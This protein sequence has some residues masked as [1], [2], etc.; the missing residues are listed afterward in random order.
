MPGEQY[1]DASP[2][3]S[4]RPRTVRLDH[5][6]VQADLVTDRG[7]FSPTRIDLGTRV[8]FDLA[9]EPPTAGRFLDLGCGYGPIAVVLATLCPDAEVWAV[10]VNE[11]SLDLTRRNCA[12]LPNVHV[13]A[14]DEVDPALRFDLVWSNPPI[15]I[16]KE[17]LHELLA[18]WLGRLAP[19]GEAVL[20]MG[21]NLGADT[22]Q[23]WLTVHVGPTERVGSK[24]GFR[25]LRV[26]QGI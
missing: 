3:S 15:R 17:A 24:K 19:A 20:V 21:K 4:T 5:R 8:L 25:V 18:T 26:G 10:D 16:G 11:R 22:H 23:R 1:F 13:A 6:G 12:A 9:P 2:T 14:P 7:V